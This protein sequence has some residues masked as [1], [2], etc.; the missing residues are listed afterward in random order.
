[1]LISSAYYDFDNYSQ[2]VK[3]FIDDRYY[4]NF[5]S[6]FTIET[7]VYV[8]ENTFEQSDSIYRYDSSGEQGSFV[9]VETFTET[10][11]K[12]DAD[13]TVFQILFLKDQKFVN[14]ERTVLSFLDCCGFIGGVNEIL[15]LAGMLVVSLVSKRI[16]ALTL[17]AELYQINF[18]T[19]DKALQN[20]NHLSVL[21][22]DQQSFSNIDKNKHK[23][24]SK[25]KKSISPKS[26][27]KLRIYEENLKS[28]S[29]QIKHVSYN[30]KQRLKFNY[31]F[32]D[33]LYNIFW[34][35]K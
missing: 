19:R 21:H 10:P 6:G 16:F 35:F 34:P 20:L 29:D 15:H 26:N 3:H 30:M 1:M 13:G 23:L 17:L 11:R 8:R 28:K 7:D 22:E 5:I 9:S 2:S 32:F 25:I 4:F 24:N 31:S 12:Q 27:N 14:Y 33:L 18:D